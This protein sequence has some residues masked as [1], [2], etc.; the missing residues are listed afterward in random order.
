MDCFGLQQPTWAGLF[1]SHP[2]PSF[3]AGAAHAA[4]G[5]A[6]QGALEPARAQEA[7]SPAAEQGRCPTARAPHRDDA[8]KKAAAQD[9]GGA[10]RKGKRAPPVLPGPCPENPPSRP[11]SH[12]AGG[13]CA[14]ALLQTGGNDFLHSP[15][16][17]ALA[18]GLPGRG[19]GQET[20][21][22]QA[23][24]TLCMLSGAFESALSSIYFRGGG[25]AVACSPALYCLLLECSI[26]YVLGPAS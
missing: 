20:L 16:P 15:G 13:G 10:A 26:G 21:R 18:G 5:G 6:I 14:P 23:A 2:E 17:F 9:S 8:A 12:V 22:R 25:N 7:P 4:L 19:S 1:S 24:V 3:L 11:D